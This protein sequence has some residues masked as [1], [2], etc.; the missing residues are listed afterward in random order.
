MALLSRRGF[1]GASAVSAAALLLPHRSLAAQPALRLR[2]TTRTL[3]IAGRAITVKGILDENGRSGLF[4]NPDERFYV[5]L[6]N[7]LETE[8]ILHW[9]GQ[10]PPNLQ[11]G[12]PDS[13]RPVMQVGER[14]TYD[15][16]AT[17]GTHWMHAHKPLNLGGIQGR[18]EATGRGIQYALRELFR[19][20]EDAAH[21]GLSGDLEGKRIVV[22]GLAMSAI[23]QPSSSRKRMAQRSPRSSNGTA[24]SSARRSTS[25]ISAS[26]SSRPARSA[27]MCFGVQF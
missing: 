24:R 23:M 1:L 26:G 5:E 4:L 18:V 10:I 7:G 11:D 9:H 25:R 3:D 8:T 19:H 14:R 16:A 21:A 6:E 27:I 15:F 2:A 13:P 20:P 22:Q 17:P 12:V